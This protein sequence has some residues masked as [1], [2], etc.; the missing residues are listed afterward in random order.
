MVKMMIPIFVLIKRTKR[1][2]YGGNPH[3]DT[4]NPNLHF[5]DISMRN[6]K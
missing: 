6:P 3:I 1:H 2:F 5:P 4:Q